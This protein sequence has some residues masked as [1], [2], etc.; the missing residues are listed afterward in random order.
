[1]NQ[2]QY[3]LVFANEDSIQL[4][5]IQDIN[6]PNQPDD[7]ELI[8]EYVENNYGAKVYEIVELDAIEKITI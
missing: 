3:L 7:Y 1:M 8:A 4:N 5:I 6:R 2:N